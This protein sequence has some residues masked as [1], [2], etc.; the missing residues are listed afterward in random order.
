MKR[1]DFAVFATLLS[2]IVLF[3]T[4]CKENNEAPDLVLNATGCVQKGPFVSGSSITIYDL[5]NDLSATGKSFNTQITDNK[6]T[7]N[8]DNISLSSNY[9]RLR[10]DGFYFNEI[11]GQ[12]SIAQISLFALAD[13]TNNST[14]N[15]NLLTHLEKSRVEFLMNNGKTFT[16]AKAQAQQEVLNIFNVENNNNI[17]PSESL[18]ISKTGE[19]NAVLLAVS[20]I[21]QGYR[22]E[23]ELTELLANISDDIKQDGILS[24]KDLGSA[25]INHA[26][27]LDTIAIKNNLIKRYSDLGVAVNVPAFGKYIAN[28]IQKTDYPITKTVINYPA[29]G[30]YGDNILDLSKTIYTAYHDYSFAAQ[31]PNNMFLKITVIPILQS[32]SIPFGSAVMH[33]YYGTDVNWS[34]VERVEAPKQII[35]TTNSTSCDYKVF[36]D[37]GSYLLKYYENNSAIPTRQKTIEMK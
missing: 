7:F 37:K 17:R 9:V 32:D 20:S 28:F 30:M 6:G 11:S 35:F 16:E 19:D 10:A 18:D 26:V 4:G 31:L 2:V 27:Y 3:L 34:I 21:L 14:I 12:Q 8:I 15:V 1:T 5:K 24:N 33:C 25:L 36:F 23:G 29:S 22:N 13:I